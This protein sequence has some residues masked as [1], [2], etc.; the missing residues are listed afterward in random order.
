MIQVFTGVLIILGHFFDAS[1]WEI[2][3]M[4]YELDSTVPYLV[5]VEARNRTYP[6]PIPCSEPIPERIP[7][8]ESIPIPE[9]IPEPIPELV[10]EPI[11]EFVPEPIPEFRNQFQNPYRL[12]NWNRPGNRN[13]LR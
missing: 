11:P 12:R 5:V 4:L 7:M 6:I 2:N 3:F 9:S 8:L 1:Q 13:L 10:P